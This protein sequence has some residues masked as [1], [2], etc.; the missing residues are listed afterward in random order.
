MKVVITRENTLN[1]LSCFKRRRDKRERER[2]R[3]RE[4][5]ELRREIRQKEKKD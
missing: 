2:E 4:N 5:G 1:F 3:E